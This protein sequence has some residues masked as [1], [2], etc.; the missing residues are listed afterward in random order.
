MRGHKGRKG[1]GVS[2]PDAYDIPAMCCAD[3]CGSA[4][5][6]ED[7][8]I[9][10]DGEIMEVATPDAADR[11]PVVPA[12]APVVPAPVVPTAAAAAAVVDCA[13]VVPATA[14]DLAA[15][16]AA[17]HDDGVLD[18]ERPCRG[19]LAAVGAFL[20]TFLET[21]FDI[22]K[23]TV[24]ILKY[25]AIF[26]TT[27][28]ILLALTGHVVDA[29]TECLA[30]ICAVFP[31]FYACRVTAAADALTATFGNLGRKAHEYERIDFPALMAVQSRTLDQ[32][33]AHSAAGSQ[34]ALGVKHAELAVKDLTIVI[35]A[36]NLTSKDILGRSLEEFAQQ[37]KGAAR[38]LQQLSAKL[39]GAV[40]TY[41]FL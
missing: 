5:H 19:P 34:L 9:L 40:D 41:V 8:E 37:A 2:S 12:P 10:E 25:P 15:E 1:K 11:A 26:F 30:P 18:G 38:D 17:F 27:V 22:V 20:R 32:L 14:A 4:A 13:P 31:G 7:G 28:Y 35:K 21:I 3:A 6:V 33:L 29:V 24:F 16:G 23:W 36:S 39:Y